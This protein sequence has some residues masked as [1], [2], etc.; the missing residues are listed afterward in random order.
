[1]F[2]TVPLSII[3]S[4]SLYTQQWY[5]SYSSADSLRTGSEQNWFHPDPARKLS[6]NLYDINHFRVYGEKLLTTDRGTVR[7]MKS[8]IPKINL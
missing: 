3:G 8:F 4:F 5:M 2:R 7:N 6:A 1:M